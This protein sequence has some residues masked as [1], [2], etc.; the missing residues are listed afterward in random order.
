MPITAPRNPFDS[1]AA[2]GFWK[3]YPALGRAQ[4][5]FHEIACPDAFEKSPRLAM[6]ALREIRAAL[7]V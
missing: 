5:S 2:H 3:A 7:L 1:C 6:G 4:I